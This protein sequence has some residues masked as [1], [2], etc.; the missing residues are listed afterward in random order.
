MQCMRSNQRTDGT[1]GVLD[2]TMAVLTVFTAADGA[3]GLAELARRSGVPKTTTHRLCTHLVRH[4]MLERS[5]YGYCV[6][7][8]MFELGQLVP[9]R[10]DLREQAAPVLTDLQVA[11]GATVHLG[12]L[13][14]SDVVYI[15]I[16]PGAH[17]KRLPSRVGGRFPAHATAVGK[18]LLA[19][20]RRDDV[21]ALV[22][23][24]L[25]R[26]TR[27]TIVMPGKLLREL[28]NVAHCG[29][30][31]EHEESA[32]GV[33]CVASAI[34]DHR[35]HA[36][37]AISISTLGTGPSIDRFAPAVQTAALTLTRQLAPNRAT[38]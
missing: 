2:R 22:G 5:Q 19:Y 35:G 32:L 8:R 36:I 23:A 27:H 16:L 26:R 24:G 9:L 3:L 6:G 18:V 14:G 38:S 30:A 15:E 34:L 28:N 33:S 17:A 31:F 37:A 4:G 21:V 29:I 13:D 12:V 1:S 7:L 10:R 11:T 25:E 20:A